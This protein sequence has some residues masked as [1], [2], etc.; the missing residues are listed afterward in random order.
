MSCYALRTAAAEEG[1]SRLE[2]T[3]EC[4]KATGEISA[5][6]G[7]KKGGGRGKGDLLSFR[8]AGLGSFYTLW[9]QE[10]L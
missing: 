10:C 1:W 6:T 8:T 4:E 9:M 3:G 7:W 2:G 5:I